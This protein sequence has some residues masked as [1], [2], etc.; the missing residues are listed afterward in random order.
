MN[1]CK[2]IPV[3]MYHRVTDSDTRPST[4]SVDRF[5]AQMGMLHEKRFHA[6]TCGEVSEWIS[7][8]RPLPARPVVI[9]FD[10]GYRNNYE[11]AF[12][13]M[14]EFHLKATVF[15]VGNSVG[16]WNS[17]EKD[18]TLPKY[19]LMGVPEIREMANA[20]FEFGSHTLNHHAMNQIPLDKAKEEIALSKRFLEDLLGIPI[21]SFSYPFNGYNPAV[22]NAVIESGYTSACTAG[23]G[24]RPLVR[25]G[26][27]DLFELRRILVPQACG[28]FEYRIRVS[29]YYLFLKDLGDKN[30]W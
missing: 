3:L 16:A 23:S 20:G 15:L 1:I 2:E 19:P 29:G 18:S 8:R 27:I 22:K 26:S 30:R 21:I 9:T 25:N 14:K 7:A 28:L 24:P 11:H 10:D 4:V 5:R 12:P 13:I 17:W 6:M